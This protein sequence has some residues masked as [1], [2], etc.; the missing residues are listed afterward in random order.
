MQFALSMLCAFCSL[1]LLSA[2]TCQPSLAVQSQA[3][4]PS[5]SDML[6]LEARSALHWRLTGAFLREQSNWCS[7]S[8][9]GQA[10]PVWPGNP[11][12][13]CDKAE[14]QSW[15]LCPINDP[16]G[17]GQIEIP[18]AIPRNAQPCLFGLI[19][20]GRRHNERHCCHVCVLDKIII[21]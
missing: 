2:L 7:E 15:G 4:L 17:L 8:R 5:N 18:Q 19:P 9:D 3:F 14:G 21:Q 20:S 12:E 1:I 10:I 13:S 16:T 6:P 11:R